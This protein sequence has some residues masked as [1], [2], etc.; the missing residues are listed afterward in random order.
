VVL[1]GRLVWI[2]SP[3]GSQAGEVRL[4]ASSDHIRDHVHAAL[5]C[6]TPQQM[7]GRLEIAL[8][9]ARTTRLRAGSRA[10]HELASL[11]AGLTGALAA[12]GRGER[13]VAEAILRGLL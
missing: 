10:A 3:R 2:G 5:G 6:S 1:E 11:I 4:R 7:R 12:I 8:R 13:L 9:K